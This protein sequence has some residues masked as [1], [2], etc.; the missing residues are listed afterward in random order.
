MTWMRA[1]TLIAAAC[2]APLA[3][4]DEFFPATNPVELIAG[5]PDAEIGEL[6]FRGGVEITP[7]KAGIGG[8]SGLEWHEGQLYAVT[9]DGRWV[10]MTPDDLGARLVDVSSIRLTPLRD[11]KGGKLTGKTRGDAEAITRLPSGEWLIAFEQEHRIWRYADLAGPATGE[12]TRAAVL[13]AGASANGGIETLAAWPGGLLACGEWADPARPNCLRITGDGARGLHLAA[14]EGIAAAGGVPTDA[15]C[16][17]DGTCFILFRSYRPGEGNRAAIVALAPD[18]SQTTLAVLAPPMLLDNFE[19]LAVREEP[20]RTFLYLISDDNFRN[21]DSDP[22]PG[23]QRT[24]LMKF[25]IAPPPAGPAPLTPAD[26]APTPTARPATRPHPEAASVTVVLETS[27]GPVT[28]ALETERAPITAGNFLRYVEEKRLDGTSFYR[29]MNLLGARE[30]SGLVQGGVRNDPKRVLAPIAHEPTS[31]TGL[32]HRHGAVA[33]AMLGAGTADGD[34]FVVIEDQTG[35]D[36]DPA[37]SEAAWRDGFAVFG[38][39]T[40]GMEVIASIHAAARD[41]EAGEGV[42]KGQMLAEPVRIISARRAD[43]SSP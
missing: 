42:M 38:Y 24:L 41:P 36:A 12:D 33:M 9:D 37:A 7:D 25:E 35:F 5:E 20:G 2:T 30:P 26:F 32:S 3:A 6:R 29:A 34:F 28:I 31:A 40:D 19:G 4:Q 13:I 22:K 18:D 17:A 16:K 11:L 8:I 43:P 15:A 23:C 14:P 21:C 10:V 39:V 1:L 27:L